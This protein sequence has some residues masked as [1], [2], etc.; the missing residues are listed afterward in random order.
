MPKQY[1]IDMVAEIESNVDKNAGLFVVSST[2]LPLSR[3][4][5]CVISFASAAPR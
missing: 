1:K 4:R 3:L 5:S 2:A